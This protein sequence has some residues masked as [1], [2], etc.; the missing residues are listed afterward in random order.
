MII[1]RLSHAIVLLPNGFVINGVQYTEN[2]MTPHVFLEENTPYSFGK[3][4]IAAD[5]SNTTLSE[6]LE[7]V[8]IYLLSCDKGDV[9]EM[10]RKMI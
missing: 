2:T 3:L 5:G 6:I 9:L 8:K 4:C 10:F 1:Q 7:Q